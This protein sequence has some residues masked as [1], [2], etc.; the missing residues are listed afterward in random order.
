MCI[1]VPGLTPVSPSLV[2]QEN[3]RFFVMQLE[4]EK[5]FCVLASQLEGPV[6]EFVADAEQHDAQDAIV[7]DFFDVARRL[8][9]NTREICR[10]LRRNPTVEKRLQVLRIKIG[11][12]VY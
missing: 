4:L 9:K 2:G 3:E 10:F 5:Q 6:S 11:Y 1:T 7:H 12:I 8:R